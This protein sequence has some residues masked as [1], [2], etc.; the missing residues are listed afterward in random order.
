MDSHKFRMTSAIVA[1]TSMG[2]DGDVDS[3]VDV[4]SCVLLWLNRRR[5]FMAAVS[6]DFLRCSLLESDW[7]D[8]MVVLYKQR[9]NCTTNC[10]MDVKERY[11]DTWA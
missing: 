8:V 3:V 7:E 1:K 6:T 2:G 10:T 11:F 4:S 5:R 9:N